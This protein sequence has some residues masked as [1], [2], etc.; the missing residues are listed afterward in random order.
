M[1]LARAATEDEA[2]NLALAL[3][4]EPPTALAEDN[5]RARA[6]R[7]WFG[8]ARAETLRATDWNFAGSTTVPAR[9]PIDGAGVLKKRYPLPPDC[10]MVRAVDRLGP[11][12][13]AVET[14]ILDSGGAPAQAKILTTNADAPLV[15]YTRDV[16]EVALWDPTFL[17]AF[18]RRLA[19]YMAPSF[20]KSAGDIQGLE[21][22]A[23]AAIGMAARRDAREGAPRAVSRDTSWIR[24]RRGWRSRA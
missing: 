17:T 3:L 12:E 24:A 4:R 13:W 14:A 23:E 11:D 6:A 9:H 15:T 16:A 22:G 10:L 7:L 21:S 18:V 19:A 8:T 2:A 20:G 1:P 5:A